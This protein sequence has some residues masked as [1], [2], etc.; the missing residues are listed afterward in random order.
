MN[1][2]F[3]AWFAV[4]CS[5]GLLILALLLGRRFWKGR[6]SRRWQYYIWLLVILR[7]LLPF[8]PGPDLPGA[9]SLAFGQPAAQVAAD[10]AGDGPA[11][12][13]PG[14]GR[15]GNLAPPREGEAGSLQE[16]TPR[17]L[18]QAAAL[19]AEYAW[20]VWLA[21]ALG[22]LVRKLT[23]WQEF[24]RYLR[25]GA[26]PVAE[27]E[28]LDRLSAAAEQ[29]GVRRPV[30]LWEAPA[31][32]SPLLTG[33]FRPCIVL[34][35][36]K[37]PEKKFRHIVLHELTHF[38]RGDLFYKWLVQLT[39]CLHWFNPL[40][41]LMS[42]EIERACELS[43][44]EAV[45]ARLGREN[46]PEYGGTLLDAMAAGYAVRA[47]GALLVSENKRLLQER[48][49]AIMQFRGQSGPAGCLAA[50][51]TLCLALLAA[52]LGA[53][54][55]AAEAASRPEPPVH[56]GLPEAA[57]SGPGQ[58]ASQIGANEGVGSQTAAGPGSGL[59]RY[60]EAG[61]LPLFGLEFSRLEEGEQQAWLERLYAGGDYAFFSAAVRGL[62]PDSPLREALAEKAY[63][64]E[65]TAFFSMLADRME[66]EELEAWL[67]RAL[68]DGSWT[69]QSVLFDRLGRGGEFDKEKEKREQEAEA[70]QR[71]EYAAVGVTMDG[72]VYYYEGQRVNVFLD[73]RRDGAFYTLNMDPAGVV[74][75]CI[76]RDAEDRV[77]GAALMT[78]EEVTELLGDLS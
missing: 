46:A 50:L 65:E 43:C 54:S 53:P 30:E 2:F 23:A 49:A 19:L 60:Y 59:E 44:D 48:L 42:R 38:R 76:L 9:V 58:A 25:A 75:L 35:D 6:L 52:C 71:A 68:E 15:D 14:E 5:G 16:K 8:G 11:S 26:V 18:G 41:H 34:P 55:A 74:H 64:E 29:A 32:S 17:P 69:F 31:V 12:G 1:T 61:S 20:L 21:G 78:E 24:M 73:I 36:A 77:T 4:S 22:L 56:A 27:L 66:P 40:V 72:G 70:A 28:T 3:R 7:L 13:A 39:V 37:L 33:F 62:G 10:T 67:D 57:L 51:L 47:P 45:L 63:R